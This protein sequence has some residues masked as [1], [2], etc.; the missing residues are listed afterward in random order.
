[1]KFIAGLRFILAIAALAACAIAL[2]N[3]ADSHNRVID[4]SRLASNS[5]DE[6]SVAVLDLL[7]AHISVTAFVPDNA[8]LRRGVADFFGRYQR[9][10]TDLQVAFVDPR[11][12]VQIARKLGA[13]LGEIVL[14]Y[15]DRIERIQRLSE[16]D[17]TNALARLARGRDRYI[18]FLAGNGERQVGR[19]A[20]R[21]AS[22]FASYLEQ[23]GLRVR[24]FKLGALAS[25]P[26]NTAVLVIASPQAAYAPG[27]LDEINRYVA[28]GGN[29][30][31][32]SEP[33]QPAE[34]SALAR[35]LG[36]EHLSG[37]VVDPVGLTKFRNPAYAAVLDHVEHATL[38]GFDQTLVFP[39]AAALVATPNIDWQATTVAHTGPEAWT[40]NGTFEGNVGF[41][42][43]DEIQGQLNLVVALTKQRR[44]AAE[45]RVIVTGDGDFLSNTFVENLG[46]R[47]FGRR[48]LEWLAADD[49]L[50]DIAVAE[51]P[52]G[53]L[54][55]AMWQ[56]MAIF[57]VFAVLVPLSLICNGTLYWWRRRHA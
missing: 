27:E 7:D 5:I 18:T 4:V 23:R 22:E 51:I 30:L 42:A 40:E 21:D 3:Y 37:T 54:D 16:S 11:E 17:M 38:A 12:D 10:K 8:A 9:H 31:W 47:D 20:N 39:Y 49:A 32:L 44:G 19:A 50:I 35:A 56:R 15:E 43:A 1:M 2:C 6:K 33:D 25:I 13:R 45:Q 52:D 28:G 46:N 26:N 34:M 53:V 48:L 29:L 57:M 55:I 36:V 24:A 14:V 41:D